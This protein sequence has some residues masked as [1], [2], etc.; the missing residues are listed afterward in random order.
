MVRR[1]SKRCKLL[2]THLEIFNPLLVDS[3]DVLCMLLDSRRQLVLP[4]LAL[5]QNFGLSRPGCRR[6]LLLQR[7]GLALHVRQNSFASL[8]LGLSFGTRLGIF[9]VAQFLNAQAAHGLFCSPGPGPVLALALTPLLF[10]EPLHDQFSRSGHFS[11]QTLLCLCHELRLCQSQLDDSAHC[12]L[13]RRGRLKAQSRSGQA[14][15]KAHCHVGSSLVGQVPS[16][17]GVCSRGSGRRL[18]L[19]QALGRGGRPSQVFTVN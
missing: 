9:L 8:Q 15:L 10:C 6:L 16:L 13:A 19:Q 3:I 14:G 18:A 11:C 4:R 7:R 17:G 2:Q 5:H 12:S 1:K